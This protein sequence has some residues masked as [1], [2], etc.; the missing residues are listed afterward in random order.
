MCDVAETNK[1]QLL[2]FGVSGAGLGSCA[3]PL[4]LFE[5]T[6][7]HLEPLH[8]R[9]VAAELQRLLVKMGVADPAA[10]SL[11]DHRHILTCL[12]TT[13][14]LPGYAVVLWEAMQVCYQR[15]PPDRSLNR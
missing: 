7:V 5:L 13:A 15:A 14:G 6:D 10:Q 2:V 11:L 4:T 8:L 9:V 3:L 12:H 1:E